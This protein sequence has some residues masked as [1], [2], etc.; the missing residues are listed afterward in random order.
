[1]IEQKKASKKFEEM[2]KLHENK[3]SDLKEGQVIK[4]T[5]VDITAKEVIIDIGYKSEGIVSIDEFSQGVSLKVGGE[6]EVLLES[7]EDEEGLVI[8][9]KKKANQVQNW[10]DISR[11]CN[12]GSIIEGKVFR[13]VKGGL[14]VDIGMEA[15]LP[16]SQASI[17]PTS[18][19][20]QFIG[21]VLKF[22]I[23]KTDRR[24]KNVV[25]SHRDYLLEEKKHLKEKLLGEIEKGQLCKGTVKNITDFGAFIDLGGLD[26]LLHITDMSW[27]RISHPSEI[28]AIGDEIEVLVLNFDKENGRV[29][30]GLK[31]KSPSPWTDINK[32][33]PV[34]SRVKGRV[35]NIVPYGVFIEL[36]K[37][38]EGLVHISELSWTRRISHPSEI[39]AIGDVVEAVVLSV[40][41]AAEKISL[42]IKQV[43]INPWL[44]VKERYK[45]G[46]EV[47]GKVRSLTKYGVFIELETGIDGLLHISDIFWTKRINHPSEI[48]KKGEK[49]KV[50]ILAVDQETK[51]I[52][53]GLK[54]LEPDPWPDIVKKYEVGS[55][56]TGRI[57]AITDFGVFVEI[58]KGIEGL[59]HISLTAAKQ[60]SQLEEMFK[61]DDKVKVKVVKADKQERKIALEIVT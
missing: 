34:G 10:E 36:E 20:D 21:R 12:E 2:L 17:R 9:S 26:G 37:G 33:Y 52:S 18:N 15:F 31:Q 45:V 30:L 58:A 7:K 53:L 14:I 39:L 41:E 47:S 60:P 3:W 8:L 59:V 27:S 5:I 16:A 29:S 19:L 54:Q 1:M 48:L 40:D 38:I 43:E 24:R 4:G 57:T 11:K 22:K 6:V 35:V 25:L 49:V 50:K 46:A 56:V 42:G 51:K 32:K 61:V 23:V 13:K 44:E 55:M 28:L